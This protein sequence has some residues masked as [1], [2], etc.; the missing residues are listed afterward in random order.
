[1][2]EQQ[3]KKRILLALLIGAGTIYGSQSAQAADDTQKFKLDPMIVTAQR[4]EK[5]DLDTPSNVTIVSAEE[6]RYC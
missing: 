4:T 6:I 5:R 1:M 2:F 3:M